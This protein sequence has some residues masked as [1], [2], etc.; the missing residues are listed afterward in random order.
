MYE[1]TYIMGHIAL[2]LNNSIVVISGLDFNYM[3]QSQLPMDEVFMYNLYTEQWSKHHI[4]GDKPTT[5][6]RACAAVIQKEIYMFGGW[7]FQTKDSF[8]DL[9][10][11][12]SIMKG[13]GGFSWC[14]IEFQCGVKLPACRFDHSA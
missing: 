4:P 8:N 2:R 11:L 7:S 3:D 10:K 6:Y 9:W 14:K 12:T 1:H 13:L 5:R